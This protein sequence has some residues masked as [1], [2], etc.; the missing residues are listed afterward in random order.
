[1]PARS[2]PPDGRRALGRAGEDLVADH[3]RRAGYDVLARNWRCRA[4]ELDL[5]VRRGAVVVFCEVKT[6]RSSAFGTGAEAVTREKRR[7]L[8]QLAARFLDESVVRAREL[9]FDVAAVTWTR[10]GGPDLDLIEGAF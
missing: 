2:R 3:Y 6:R 9:R 7:R 1:M 5:V 10:G 4:G 8:R